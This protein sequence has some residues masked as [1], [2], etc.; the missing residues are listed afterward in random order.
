M[1][2]GSVFTSLKG[3]REGY[4]WYDLRIVFVVLV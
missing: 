1:M 2:E 4:F 3:E